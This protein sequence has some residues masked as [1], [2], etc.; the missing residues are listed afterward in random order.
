MDQLYNC[1]ETGNLSHKK[2]WHLAQ[3]STSG[4]K[5]ENYT[6]A[7]TVLACSH[8]SEKLKMP[9]ANISKARMLDE[10]L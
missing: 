9:L 6:L 8:A 5:R 10:S 7:N 3:F 4:Y 2:H 1:D